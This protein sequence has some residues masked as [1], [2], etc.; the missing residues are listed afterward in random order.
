M[1]ISAFGSLFLPSEYCPL[2]TSLLKS[3]LSSYIARCRVLHLAGWSAI[4][5]GY[6]WPSMSTRDPIP[7][8]SPPWSS[9]RMVTVTSQPSSSSRLWTRTR[10]SP[11]SSPGVQSGSWTGAQ[12]F[13]PRS[14]SGSQSPTRARLWWPTMSSRQG[15][16][17]AEPTDQSSTSQPR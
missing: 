1:H 14:R 15:G 16:S 8:T 4:T 12:L 5:P 9:T 10:G 7:T 11:C 2:I 17:P 6:Q 13:R 3:W